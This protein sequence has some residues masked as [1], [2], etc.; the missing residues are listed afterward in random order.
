[1]KIL[2]ISYSYT[3]D[4]NPR[5]LRWAALSEE[6]VKQD[7]EVYVVTR[8]RSIKERQKETVNGVNIRRVGSIWSAQI[9]EWLTKSTPMQQGVEIG[10]PYQIH[11]K[12]FS[13]L[14]LLRKIAKFCYNLTWKRIYW[15]DSSCL[16]ILSAVGCAYFLIRKHNLN[17]LISVSHPFSDH[18][19]GLLLNKICSG[20]NWLADN[21]DPFA[22]LEE[23][24]P[25]NFR[26]WG[27]L[28]F[29]I[30]NKVISSVSCF[31]VT[32]A[33][34]AEVY[35]RLFP[36]NIDKILVIPHLLQTGIYQLA[37]NVTLSNKTDK[38]VLLFVGTFYHKIRNPGLLLDLLEQIIC[39][40]SKLESCLQLQIIGSTNNMVVEL[41]ENR[42]N[43][44]SKVFLYEKLPHAKAM[45]AM[46]RADC[47][48]NIG[49]A[50]HYQMPTKVIEYMFTGKPIL[51]LTTIENDSSR[52]VLKSYP[53]AYDWNIN[54]SGN[55]DE[56]C[57]FLENTPHL[58][59]IDDTLCYVNDFTLDKI[60]NQYLSTF[61]RR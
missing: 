48:V 18:V 19:V 10:S 26:I 41:L 24:P 52:Q 60:S 33:S 27:K 40:S 30:E 2:I 3:P 53:Y 51:N 25:N 5:A 4:R 38:I 45:A 15:P 56:L 59:R 34:T 11:S 37:D 31:A 22:F 58:P 12:R 6:W 39:H 17:I 20:L 28:N 36:N 32:T 8:R 1:M 14:L 57:Y 9:R 23:S 29:W 43:L 7:H 35:Q 47:L 21:G 42:P 61:L 55:L 50:T 54:N 16:W 13:I 44:I 49:N 46:F